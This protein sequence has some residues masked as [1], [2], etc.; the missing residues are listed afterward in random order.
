M[1]TCHQSGPVLRTTSAS[2]SEFT[3]VIPLMAARLWQISASPD[4]PVRP[5]HSTRFLKSEI[6]SGHPYLL[7]RRSIIP[8]PIGTKL[9]AVTN[10]TPGTITL[11]SAA[12]LSGR[13]PLVP[14]PVLGV[15]T[16]TNAISRLPTISASGGTCAVTATPTSGNQARGTFA[17]TGACAAGN[18]V[19]LTFA[20]NAPTGWFCSANTVVSTPV[21]FLKSGAGSATTA[22][23]TPTGTT[24]ATDSVSYECAPY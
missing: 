7:I 6:S 21:Q 15:G 23:M 2:R 17:L 4:L 12:N 13:F 11:G 14:L 22:V 8:F 19:T 3:S 9:T 16:P 24:G 1:L 10:G 20:I 18:T 5:R